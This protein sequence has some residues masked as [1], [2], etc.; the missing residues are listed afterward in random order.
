MRIVKKANGEE[1]ITMG[2]PEPMMPKHPDP[3]K[4]MIT[5]SNIDA[6]RAKRAA[7]KEAAEKPAAAERGAAKSGK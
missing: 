4:D 3:F 2:G 1:M 7:E 6:I 5:T